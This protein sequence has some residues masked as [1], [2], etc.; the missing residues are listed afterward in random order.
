M[1]A[2]TYRVE[3]PAIFGQKAA[4]WEYKARD[5]ALARVVHQ[6][7]RFGEDIDVREIIETT[8]DAIIVTFQIDAKR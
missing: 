6:M 7:T 4:S 8:S 2:D 5:V 1:A 3:R